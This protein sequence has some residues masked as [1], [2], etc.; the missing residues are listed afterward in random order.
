MDIRCSRYTIHQS[1]SESH[2]SLQ[3]ILETIDSISLLSS[4]S[5]L[6]DLHITI[7]KSISFISPL[8]ENGQV[9]KTV[10]GD[11]IYQPAIDLA[12]EKLNHSQWVHVF[13]EGKVN[14]PSRDKSQNHE[15]LRF[16]WGI[17]RLILES[18]H[19]PIILPI[20]LTGFDD[21]MPEGRPSP[22]NMIPRLNQS[23]SIKI[24]NPINDTRF[25]SCSSSEDGTE[26]HGQEMKNSSKIRD[27]RQRYQDLLS[28][29]NHQEPIKQEDYDALKDHPEAKQIRIELASFLHAQLLAARPS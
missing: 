1:V 2:P 12:L 18:K 16:K 22:Y 26:E 8:F 9:I 5:S 21:V 15:L 27:F 4:P 10:R 23:L 14:Q 11:G 29:T 17:S 13:P 7:V 19:E 3:N 28:R 24:S 25:A 20:W 6:L